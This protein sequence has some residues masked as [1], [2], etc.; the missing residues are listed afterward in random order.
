M[1]SL[2]KTIL[3]IVG[4]ALLGYGGYLLVTPEASIDIGIAEA[5]AQ[6]NDNAYITIGLGLVALLIGLLAKKK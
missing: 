1:N 5:S 2:I 6:D 3:I 4:V